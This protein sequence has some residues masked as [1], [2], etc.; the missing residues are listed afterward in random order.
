[1][2]KKKHESFIGHQVEN[3]EAAVKKKRVSRGSRKIYKNLVQWNQLLHL[4][5][6][7][8]FFLLIGP[9][10]VVVVVVSI[11]LVVFTVS[12]ALHDF[13]FCLRKL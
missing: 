7:F 4:Q 2:E 6:L 11:I 10:V 5:S 13:I 3:T 8:F 1:M 12:I 9:I